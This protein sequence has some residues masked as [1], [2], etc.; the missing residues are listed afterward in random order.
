M[1][2]INVKDSSHKIILNFN[3]RPSR[4]SVITKIEAIQQFKEKLKESTVTNIVENINDQ[5]Q[6]DTLIE[7]A[8]A[9]DMTRPISLN[10]RIEYIRKLHTLYGTNYMHDVKEQSEEWNNTKSQLSISVN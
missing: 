1:A 5:S 6:K 4:N 7:F 8:S 10:N 9:F 2:E 3:H